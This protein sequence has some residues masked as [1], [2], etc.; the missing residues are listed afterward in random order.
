MAK[1]IIIAVTNDLV[2]DQRVA[3]VAETLHQ[4]GYKITLIGRLLPYSSEMNRIYA[5]KRFKLWFN[6]GA[7]FYANYNLRLFFYLLFSQFDAILS[8]DLDTLLASFI[9]ARLKNK[10]IIYD[11][12][13]YFTQVPEL[14]N[15]RFQQKA[16]ELIE[17]AILPKLK[18]CYTVSGS[19]AN[20]YNR[21]YGTSFELIR[22]LPLAKPVLDVKKE[23]VLIYQGAVNV[24]RG[25]NLMIQS[26]Q[27]IDDMEF[28]IAGKGDVEEEMK[29]LAQDLKLSNRVRFLGRIG[30]N[31]LHEI[32]VK[33]KL[34]MSFEEDLGKN[35]RFALPNKL[36]DY[37]QARIPVLV[38]KLP[39]MEKVITNYKVGEV[40]SSRKPEKVA[41][42][43]K[44]LLEN[45]EKIE[46]YKNNLDLSANA[47][48]WEHE[49]QKLLAI[50]EKALPIL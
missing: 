41:N 20:E 6:K 28:W 35:Y 44:L 49:K 3:R 21:V 2:T 14:V 29:Q 19:I 15:R 22:N 36:F 42:Q 33:A 40:L 7:L 12:H 25:I 37:I 34:G 46:T 45:K 43:I 23:N 47:L 13:E 26:L 30:I 38:S 16:W 5:T 9:A 48:T 8:N 39:E 1:H 11:S 50:F 4:K 31:E 17:R 24:G 27:Y 32:T 18:Y 10:E